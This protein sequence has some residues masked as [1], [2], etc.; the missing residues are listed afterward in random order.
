M[1]APIG[2]AAGRPIVL[3]GQRCHR[4][5][6]RSELPVAGVHPTFGDLGLHCLLQFF[7]RADLNLAD[8]LAGDVVLLGQVFQRGRIVLK[9]PLDQ[10]VAFPFV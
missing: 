7:E 10:D 4:L 6:A 9:P 2:W 3:G 8:A 1:K 5:P